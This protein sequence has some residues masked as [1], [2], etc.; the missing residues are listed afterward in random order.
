[1]KNVVF[2]PK[3]IILLFHE[4]LLF[5]YGGSSGIRDHKL[6]DSALKQPEATFDGKYLHNTLIK[7]AAA[8][9]YH[10]CNNHPFVD[11]NK[12]IAIVAM[13]VFLQRNGYEIVASEKDTYKMMMNLSSG[14]L[15]KEEL[16][17]WLENNTSSLISN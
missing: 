6:L 7:M 17:T 5:N 13:D 10:L 12:R 15:T 3:Q 16:T 8:Y 4:Q 11:G 9:G 2:L 14:N 1:M